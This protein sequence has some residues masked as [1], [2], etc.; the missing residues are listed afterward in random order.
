MCAAPVLLMSPGKVLD[1]L[2]GAILSSILPKGSVIFT[3]DK[4]D[5]DFEKI[6]TLEVFNNYTSNDN[7]PLLASIAIDQFCLEQ[8]VVLAEADVLRAAEL[9]ARHGL[10]GQQPQEAMAFRDKPLMKSRVGQVGI[11]VAPHR[12]ATTALELVEA[13]YEMGYPCVVKPPHGRGSSGVEILADSSDLDKYLQK[14]PVSD[15]GDTSRILVEAYISGD[16]YRVDGI[17]RGGKVCFSTVALYVGSHLDY[18]AGGYLGSVILP[19]EDP[20]SLAIS[21]LAQKVLEESLP[22]YTGAFHL[23]AFWTD[24]GAVFSEVGARLGGGSISEEIEVSHGVNITAESI[25]IQCGESNHMKSNPQRSLAGQ[26]HISPREG[27]LLCA[28][29]KLNNSSIVKSEIAA[30]GKTFSRMSHTNSE[31]ARAVFK[32]GS[33]EEAKMTIEEIV[34]EIENATEWSVESERGV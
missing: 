5:V 26:V 4:I 16:Q 31:F 8:V 10:L 7:I 17:C 30:P 6:A 21:S 3:S 32:A 34:N 29:E 22:S 11:P 13:I 25:R 28:P 2:G 20:K 33:V 1:R 24:Q 19:E 15:R 27:T 18:L 12:V 9:R 23:E 14:G